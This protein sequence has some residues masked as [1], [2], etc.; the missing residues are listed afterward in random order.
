MSTK[1]VLRALL[2]IA[3][4]SGVGC[5][6]KQVVT[7]ELVVVDGEGR[8]R[9]VLSARGA[10]AGRAGGDAGEDA[11]LISLLDANGTWRAQLSVV[12]GHA[13]L[14]LA[15]PAG[16]QRAA[17]SVDPDGIPLL[18]FD[19]ETSAPASRE[20]RAAVALGITERAPLLYLRARQDGP[21]VLLSAAPNG[22][23]LLIQDEQGKVLGR[24]PED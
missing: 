18:T 24:F 17:L 15:D 5:V 21:A 19:H 14:L 20:Q 12:E 9:I 7:E 11:A 22:S 16:E 8:P 2:L 6:S 3:I 1:L 13:V 10:D 23:A 4:G